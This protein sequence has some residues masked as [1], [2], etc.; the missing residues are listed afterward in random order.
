MKSNSSPNVSL[1]E[2][3]DQ[4]QTFSILAEKLFFFLPSYNLSKPFNNFW[5]SENNEPVFQVSQRKDVTEKWK[6]QK[7]GTF[8]NDTV[9]AH[10]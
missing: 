1:W 6:V 5:N 7:K 2:E 3:N 8:W 10:V 9:S 4:I